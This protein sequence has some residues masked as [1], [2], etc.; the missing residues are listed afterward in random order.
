M[1]KQDKTKG[2]KKPDDFKFKKGDPVFWGSSVNGIFRRYQGVVI[3][4]VRKGL[5]AQKVA[6]KI[7]KK[8]NVSVVFDVTARRHPKRE[9]S[10][11]I[12]QVVN[13]D[14]ESVLYWPIARKLQPVT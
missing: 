6:R 8:L 13:K 11:Y 1:P 5:D 10:S 9:S 3:A 7:N 4:T 14:G 12:V 2:K